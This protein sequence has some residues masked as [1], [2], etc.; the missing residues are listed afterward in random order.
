[1]T[2]PYY[3]NRQKG[4]AGT[5]RFKRLDIREWD[6]PNCHAH[7]D[8]AVNAAKNILSIWL[9]TSFG[10]TS[11]N[12]CLGAETLARRILDVPPESRCFSADVVH[13]F[14]FVSFSNTPHVFFQVAAFYQI[15]QASV[16]HETSSQLPDLCNPIDIFPLCSPTFLVLKKNLFN[17]YII[18]YF[19]EVNLITLL[20]LNVMNSLY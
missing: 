17:K 9:G 20:S 10:K 16:F 15:W 14:V 6:F 2:S 11:L 19:T 7:H 1:M 5:E 18:P 12:R 4:E 3:N 8:R 13:L